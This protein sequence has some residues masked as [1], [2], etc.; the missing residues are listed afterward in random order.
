MC[1]SAKPRFSGSNPLAA[2][3][4]CSPR[5]NSARNFRVGWVDQKTVTPV[6]HPE[7]NRA[8]PSNSVSC[9]TRVIAIGFGI[10]ARIGSDRRCRGSR[11][12]F[13]S[14]AQR[15]RRRCAR[16][17]R[18]CRSVDRGGG[19]TT[20]LQN[21]LSPGLRNAPYPKDRLRRRLS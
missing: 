5:P 15:T 11:G 9:P 8:L 21:R 16:V 20:A 19:A 13:F 14:Q 1:R 10:P 7:S 2:S 17:D 3:T 12:E 6:L 4:F 18:S